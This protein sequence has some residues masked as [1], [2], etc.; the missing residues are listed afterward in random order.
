VKK[1]PPS[2]QTVKET[3][4]KAASK[5]VKPMKFFG[6]SLLKGMIFLPFGFLAYD[7]Y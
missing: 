6:S 3:V 7:Y 1:A 5:I 4:K 2:T